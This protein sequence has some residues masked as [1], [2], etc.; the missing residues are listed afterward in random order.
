[1][2]KGSG[3]I[4]W[5]DLS[6]DLVFVKVGTTFMTVQ[7]KHESTSV[8]VKVLENSFYTLLVRMKFAGHYDKDAPRETD[9]ETL[10]VLDMSSEVLGAP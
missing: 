9:G 10:L 7:S 6:Q 2:Q 3:L 1:M 8:F 4:I 5:A